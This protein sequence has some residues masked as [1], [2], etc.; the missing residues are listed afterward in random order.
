MT[1][2][3]MVS[4]VALLTAFLAGW[5]LRPQLHQEHASAASEPAPVLEYYTCPMHPHI[6]EDEPGDCPICG[7]SLVKKRE[8]A[9]ALQPIGYPEVRVAP[10]VVHNF[11]IRTATVRKGNIS[12]PLTIYGYISKVESPQPVAIRSQVAGRI[13]SVVPA[14]PEQKHRKQALLI[15]IESP[16][17]ETMQQQ[18]LDAVAAGAIKEQ[19]IL[20]QKLMDLGFGFDELKQLVDTG[21]LRKTYRILAPAT[22]RLT[23][24]EVQTE[25]LVR[26]NQQLAEFEPLYSI[27]ALAQVF[28]TQWAW[29][30]PG[31]AVR[32]TN[33]SHPG[34]VWEGEVREVQELGQS[35]TT[36]VKLTVDLE[37]NRWYPAKNGM[38]AKLRVATDARRNVLLVPSS[39]VI[40]TGSRRVV[41]VA[42]GDGRFQPV[43]VRVG[44]NDGEHTAILSGLEEGMEVVA[45][46]Q[47]LLDSESQLHAELARLDPHQQ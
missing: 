16:A 30:E 4:A 44:L 19:R 43:D 31:Q 9:T 35:S 32:M 28:E 36:A 22:G 47:F 45:S 40:R 17:V 8:D 24:L 14:G 33:R 18:Y 25:Q 2:R 3:L 29:L 7:M 11:G 5:Y 26:A 46:G 23:K 6:H 12:H 15:E 20:K 21:E 1:N 27:T 39:A 10:Q 34:A 38:Q 13:L 42:K 41:V 37:A